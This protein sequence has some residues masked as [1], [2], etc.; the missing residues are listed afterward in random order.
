MKKTNKFI[1]KNLS[2]KFPTKD[3]TED[4]KKNKL[5]LS[6]AKKPITVD[7]GN[8]IIFGGKKIPIIAGPNGVESKKLMLSVGKFLKKSG[9]NILRAHAY[10][11]LTFPYRSKQYKDTQEEGMQWVD[12]VKNEFK[13]K[14]VTEVTEIQHIDRIAETADILQIGSRNMQNLE[15][16]KEVAKIQKPIILKRH[17]GA[18]LR[19]F[20]GAAEHILIEGNKKLILCERGISI[21]HTHRETSRFALDIQAIP[22]LKEICKYPII[23]DPSHASFWAPWVPSLTL[24]SV[25]AGADGLIIEMHPEPKKSAVDPLQ[26]LNYSQFKKLLKNSNKVAKAV[27]R[28]IS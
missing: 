13:L 17:F 23:S 15:L 26:P 4:D 18:S 14:I 8:G 12:I 2:N 5:M 28:I 19:D 3:I 25:A 21:P 27:G 7:I 16:L 22:A 10:K 6:T 20:L 9:V 24:A 11:P 1:V